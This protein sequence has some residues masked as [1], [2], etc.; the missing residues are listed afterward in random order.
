MSKIQKYLMRSLLY[1][2]M[3]SIGVMTTLFLVFDFLDRIDNLMAANASFISSVMYFALKIPLTVTLMLPVSMLSAVLFSYG[4]L[5]KQ[6]E[7]TAM[8]AAGL[9]LATLSKPVVIVGIAVSLT[10]FLINET[11]VPAATRKVRE[12]YNI[13]IS[14]KDKSGTYSQGDLWW[15]EGG[16]LYTVEQFDSRNNSL[17]QVSWFDLDTA[18]FRPERRTDAK[19]GSFVDNDLG[20]GFRGVQQYEF[21]DGSF[22]SLPQQFYSLSL[23]LRKNPQD[24]YDVRTDRYSLSFLEMRHFIKTQARNGIPVK[25]YLAD[26]Y[27]KLSFPWVSLLCGLVVLPFSIRPS[28]SSGL[29]STIL[30]ALVI[31]FSYYAVHY[32]SLSLGRALIWPPLLAAFMAN[33][34]L[35]SVAVI[36]NLGAEAPR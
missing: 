34:L 22:K 28:R 25:N 13:D 15:R 21:S 20:W 23:P 12:I 33:I 6:G 36:L 9:S 24:F 7:I 31:G 18:A 29:A 1:Y 35:G 26:L 19:V 16:R 4:I 2:F 30:V 14:Q 3:L 27:E 32:F 11:V 17:N 8:R 10:A 5:A